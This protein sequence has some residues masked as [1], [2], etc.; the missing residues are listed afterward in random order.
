[1]ARPFDAVFF[2]VGFTLVHFYPGLS[3]L[4]AR[5]YHQAGVH[6]E[7][8]ELR[9]AQAAAI[10]ELYTEDALLLPPNA[11]EMIGKEAARAFWQGA[12]DM[13]LKEASLTPVDVEGHGDV[14]VELYQGVGRCQSAC[15]SRPGWLVRFC[16][17]DPELVITY[18]SGF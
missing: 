12:I 5:V 9:A 2:D 13:G 6:A 10:S 3:E 7:P 11:E 4:V 1:M 15:W 18:I 8:A 16:W 17:P 14:V